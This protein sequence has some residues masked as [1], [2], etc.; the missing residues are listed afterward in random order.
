MVYDLQCV[1]NSNHASVEKVGAVLPWPMEDNRKAVPAEM[2]KRLCEIAQGSTRKACLQERA[3]VSAAPVARTKICAP[4]PSTSPS[5]AWLPWHPPRDHHP[6]MSGAFPSARP[7][8][9]RGVR[10]PIPQRSS[11]TTCA[12]SLVLMKADPNRR[13]TQTLEL[14]GLKSIF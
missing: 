6:S 7:T 10:R 4:S 14:E 1:G 2:T 12:S 13:R 5:S 8:C 11:A 3:R 9:T